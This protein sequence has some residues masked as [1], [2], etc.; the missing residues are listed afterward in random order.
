MARIPEGRNPSR[1]GGNMVEAETGVA[2]N[3]PVN[4]AVMPSPEYDV[5]PTPATSQTVENLRNRITN[6]R[7]RLDRLESRPTEE[8][9][10][11]AK[12]ET[13]QLRRQAREAIRRAYQIGFQRALSQY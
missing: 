1:L 12:Q 5:D 6:L 13:E 10:N 3:P 9:L 8:E 11:R 7:S 4:F 2:E